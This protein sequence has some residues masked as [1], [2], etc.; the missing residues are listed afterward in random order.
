MAYAQ[1]IGQ[2]FGWC[3]RHRLKLESINPMAVASY[4]EE[5]S[6]RFSA[7]TTKRHFAAIRMLFD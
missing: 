5:I 2:L 6:G 7:P 1:A 3:H 4:I